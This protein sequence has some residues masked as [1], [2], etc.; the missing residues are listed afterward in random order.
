MKQTASV[1][2][3]FCY[4]LLTP[5]A[6]VIEKTDVHPTQTFTSPLEY[7]IATHRVL[8]RECGDVT[9]RQLVDNSRKPPHAFVNLFYALKTHIYLDTEPMVWSVK[10]L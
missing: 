1:E 7:L 2:S 9:A 6:V 4:S 3:V 5:A 10:K 8:I